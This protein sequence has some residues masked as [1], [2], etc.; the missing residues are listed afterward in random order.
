MTETEGEIITDEASPAPVVTPNMPSVLKK[1]AGS[2]PSG[3]SAK[4]D[5][6][7]KSP[8]TS[9]AT[10]G[11]GSS[12]RSVLISKSASDQSEQTKAPAKSPKVS[13]RPSAPAAS[14]ALAISG[15]SPQ[16]VVQ[17]TGPQAVTVGKPAAYKVEVAND[18]ETAANDV[19][20]R[21]GLPQWVQVRGG[22]GSRGEARQ[23]KDAAGRQ[24]LVWSVP[25]LAAGGKEQ[26][27]LE[28]VVQQNQP[29]ELAMHWSARPAT[30]A[31]EIAVREPQVE[32]RLEGP[33]DM[34]FG[35]QKS[36]M[37][38][39][40]NP[41]TGDAENVVVEVASGGGA[42]NRLDVGLLLAGQQ[43]QIPFSV[44]A[45]APG[46]MEIRAAATGTGS[47]TAEASSRVI[48][49][50]P[51]LQVAIDVPPMKFAGAE[52]SYQVAVA[53]IGDAV[54]EQVTLSIA[55][56]AGA[57]YVGGLD[58]A[59]KVGEG[60]TLKLGNL[61][62]NTEKTFEVR[63]MLTQAGENHFE[64]AARGKGEL[65]ATQSAVTQ[66]EALADLKLNVTEPIAPVPVGGEAIYEVRV[67][68]RGTKSAEHVKVVVQFAQGIE[69]LEV[70]GGTA[71]VTNGQAMFEPL[72]E[73]AAGKEVVLKVKA[74]GE[75]AGSHA[76]RVEVKAGEP[77][78]KLVSEGVT[79]C[80]AEAALRATTRKSPLQPVPTTKQR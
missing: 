22:E 9:S 29:F 67:A 4:P 55:L 1:K 59:A 73:V 13:I 75:S 10:E 80:F 47:L 44:A 58:G 31:A 41:G 64:V 68:N 50:K 12:R 79:R 8:T 32:V 27:S 52:S 30:I 51:E 3:V 46:E 74:R 20:V 49:H 7:S 40:S 21:I 63:C 15:V 2:P 57:K 45:T 54:A 5:A 14:K 6:R 16:I 18:S 33:S 17:A 43:K 23:E 25:Q 78:T 69:P 42:A 48:V 62:P 71:A 39:V 11:D 19:A 38:H 53:N 60:L 72:A 36:F 61:A 37:L 35:E 66:V 65:T 24:W 28:F 77:E 76:F 26:L 56:P 34:L 70:V